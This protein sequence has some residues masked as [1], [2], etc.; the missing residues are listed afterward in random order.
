MFN[1]RNEPGISKHTCIVLFIICSTV[2]VSNIKYP[3][4]MIDDYLKSDITCEII[5]FISVRNP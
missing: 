2:F 5:S 4:A 3:K 1:T